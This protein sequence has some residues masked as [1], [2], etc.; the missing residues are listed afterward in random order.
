MCQYQW[1]VHKGKGYHWPLGTNL[2]VEWSH[3]KAQVWRCKLGQSQMP[4]MIS[5]IRG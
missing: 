2:V 4:P 5:P 3:T 1:H